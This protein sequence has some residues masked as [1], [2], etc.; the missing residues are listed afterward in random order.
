MYVITKSESMKNSLTQCFEST[1]YRKTCNKLTEISPYVLYMF[2]EE[3][4]N[5]PIVLIHDDYEKHANV[6]KAFLEDKPISFILPE[7]MPTTTYS[8]ERFKAWISFSKTAKDHSIVK[9]PQRL[10]KALKEYVLKGI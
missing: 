3:P 7:Y 8:L 6:M 10:R 2:F 9:D 5:E 4:E 1:M